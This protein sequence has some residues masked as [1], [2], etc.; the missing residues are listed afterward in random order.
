VLIA[1]V[2][3]SAIARFVIA[4]SLVLGFEDGLAEDTR[5]EAKVDTAL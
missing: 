1:D 3:Q 2:A 4:A 5:R